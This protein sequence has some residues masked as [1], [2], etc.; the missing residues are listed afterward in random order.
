MKDY[1]DKN[2]PSIDNDINTPVLIIGGG[3]AGLMC[4]YHFMKAKIDFI[5]VDSKKLASSVSAKTT[6]QVTYA[7]SNF[8]DD[9]IKKH[10]IKKAELYLESQL[11]GFKIMKNIIKKENIACDY[12]EES[13]IIG[14]YL[15]KNIKILQNKSIN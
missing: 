2:L 11:A 10:G 7:H 13:T 5:L 15:P 14:A 8:Y 1:Y 9:I 12:K 3:L 6:A 4:A